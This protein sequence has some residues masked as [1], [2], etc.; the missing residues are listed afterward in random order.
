MDSV[1]AVG[2]SPRPDLY[3][4]RLCPL[5]LLSGRHSRISAHH[6]CSADLAFHHSSRIYWH[7][8]CLYRYAFLR[9]AMEASGADVSGDPPASVEHLGA[10]RDAPPARGAERLLRL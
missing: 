2:G 6:R 1:S 5:Y 8:G 4:E 9:R 7:G 3:G 10:L